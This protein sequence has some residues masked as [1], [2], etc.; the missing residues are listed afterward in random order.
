MTQ[1]GRSPSGRRDSASAWVSSVRLP[2]PG[3]YSG[4]YCVPTRARARADIP[5]EV[6]HR[7][8][9]RPT[10]EIEGIPKTKV[11]WYVCHVTPPPEARRRR[12]SLC[13]VGRSVPHW[14]NVALARSA[15]KVVLVIPEGEE[16]A[17]E[18]EPPPC[19]AFAPWDVV[20]VM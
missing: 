9:H 5:L 20:D 12:F 7:P 2:V 1:I 18:E 8:E 6:E 13:G 17:E 15:G 14:Y 19:H 16:E 3:T 4:T 11:C 10:P